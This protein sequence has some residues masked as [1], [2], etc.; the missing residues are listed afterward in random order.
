MTGEK[1]LNYRIENLTEENQL[2][3]SFLATHTQFSKKVIVKTLK[4]LHDTE[5]KTQFMEEIKRLSRVQHPNVLTLYDHLETDQDFYLIFE[6]LEG[7][8]LDTYI[9]T[10]SGPIPE[11]R[12]LEIFIKILDAFALAH[13]HELH[14]GAIQ[15]HH[16]FITE[17]D[18]IKVLDLAL[19]EVFQEKLL[20]QQDREAISFASPE[21][22]QS[23]GT[24]DPKSDVYALGVLLFYMITAKNPYEDFNLGE[25]KEKIK[26]EPLPKPTKYYPVVS[27]E[28]QQVI[29]KATAKNPADR[30]Q[31]CEVFK[32]ALMNIQDKSAANTFTSPA[33]AEPPQAE[34]M[35]DPPAESPKSLP[36][37]VFI[38]VPLMMLGGILLIFL[39]MLYFYSQPRESERSDIIFNIKD[40]ERIRQIQ[41]SIAQAQKRKE[42]QDSI[43][44]FGSMSVRDTTDIYFYKVKRGENL[45][46]IAEKFYVPLDTLKNMNDLTGEER[47]KPRE[48]L[49][50]KVRAIYTMGRNETLVQI[51][52]KFGVSVGVLREINDLYPKP[53]EPGEIPQPVI[54]E[55]KKLIIPLN[56]T[57]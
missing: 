51:S 17:Q 42:I 54:F 3:R 45:T 22:L 18:H 24:S 7:K 57:K 14:G 44:I 55:G 2:F 1:I 36:P 56:A 53:V 28:L 47:L 16:I 35:D 39:L 32:Q 11:H 34:S 26:Q 6:Y 38:N 5:E 9:H 50:I 52:E 49:K 33:V 20:E 43:R 40:T 25:I 48:G 30:F 8:S 19:S 13:H 37:S 21:A 4:P 29:Q 10:K 41:D 46:E 31:N 15:P 27:T 12:T 23:V